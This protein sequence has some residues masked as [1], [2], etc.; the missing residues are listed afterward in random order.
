MNILIVTRY[1]ST[2]AAKKFWPSF[3]DI[4]KKNVIHTLLSLDF[5]TRNYFV[6]C[7]NFIENAPNSST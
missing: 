1:N 2:I 3:S 4:S 5:K 6:I 7:Q